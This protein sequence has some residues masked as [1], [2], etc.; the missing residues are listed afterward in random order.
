MSKY[1]VLIDGVTWTYAG[2]LWMG[3]REVWSYVIPA[4]V[5]RHLTAAELH[6]CA[7]VVAQYE[8]DHAPRTRRRVARDSQ[9]NWWARHQTLDG[10][11][12]GDTPAKVRVFALKQQY[13]DRIAAT[14]ANLAMLADLKANPDEEVPD[15]E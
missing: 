4:P 13:I 8:R 5:G 10:W 6:M 3:G 14:D 7:D 11:V 1:S 15:G 2:G 12:Y 9:G